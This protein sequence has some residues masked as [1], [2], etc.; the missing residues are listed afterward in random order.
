MEMYWP[1]Q[2][3]KKKNNLKSLKKKLLIFRNTGKLFFKTI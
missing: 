1:F 2:K 3:E